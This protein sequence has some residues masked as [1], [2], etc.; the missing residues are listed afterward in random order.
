MRE[1]GDHPVILREALLREVWGYA[2]GTESR[3]VETHL[4]ALRERLGDDVL[5]PVDQ[6]DDGV[7]GA[8]RPLNQVRVEGEHRPVQASQQNHRVPNP[9]VSSFLVFIDP[10]G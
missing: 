5:R 3:T 4:A 8:V 9:Q 2:A 1:S 6:R 7:R 10:V